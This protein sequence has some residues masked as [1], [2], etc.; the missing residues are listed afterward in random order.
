MSID[1]ANKPELAE[2][3]AI[4][5]CSLFFSLLV[6]LCGVPLLAQNADSTFEVNGDGNQT[7]QSTR[8]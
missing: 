2:R 4:I 5:L 7:D 3:V 8:R 6:V 1:R